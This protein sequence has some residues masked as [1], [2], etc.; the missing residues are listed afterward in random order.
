MKNEVYTFLEIGLAD[1]IMYKKQ[2]RRAVKNLER[3]KGFEP[4]T[5]TMAR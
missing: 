2:P 1:L 5:L 4:S 3:E